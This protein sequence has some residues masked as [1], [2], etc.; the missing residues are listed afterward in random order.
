MNQLNLTFAA[1]LILLFTACKKSK[2]PVIITKPIIIVDQVDLST[3]T[4]IFETGFNNSQIQ[5]VGLIT[6]DITGANIPNFPWN[7]AAFGNRFSISYFSTNSGGTDA[8][9][10]A[11]IINDDNT[12]NPILKFE[13][14]E[15]FAP[16]ASVNYGRIQADLYNMVNPATNQPLKEFFQSVRMKLHSGSF[17][18][19]LANQ[20]RLISGSGD[21][22]TLFEFWSDRNWGG[23][24]FPFRISVGAKKL[25]PLSTN[26]FVMH[27]DATY[28][29]NATSSWL[30]MPNWETSVN[31][32]NLAIPLGTWMKVEIYFKEGLNTNGRFWVRVTPDGGTPKIICNFFKTTHH[33]NNPSPDGMSEINPMKLYTSANVVNVAK[34][35]NQALQV[36]WDDYKLSTG[37]V[38]K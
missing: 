2:E 1:G 27:V 3:G 20:S 11:S 7:S 13:I 24:N 16:N 32:E 14:K 38:P 30:D 25:L 15:P 6:D 8:Q 19:I 9:R 29:A 34:A 21:W 26:K 17:N 35:Q 37:I 36:Y 5:T 28:Q 31:D 18:A 23:S 4:T 22:L 33:P 10:K 12:T